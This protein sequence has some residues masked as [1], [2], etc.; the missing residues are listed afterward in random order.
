MS[1]K[2]LFKEKIKN[3]AKNNWM[4]AGEYLGVIWALFTFISTR[5]FYIFISGIWIINSYFYHR[6]FVLERER[7]KNAMKL[8]NEMYTMMCRTMDICKSELERIKN[9]SK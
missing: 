1:E 9:L 3:L 7:T 2:Y 8:S 4:Y 6:M 5:D